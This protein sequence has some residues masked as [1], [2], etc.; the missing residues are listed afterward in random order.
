VSPDNIRADTG[1]SSSDIEA[2]LQFDFERMFGSR[3][4]SDAAVQEQLK[5]TA[6][7]LARIFAETLDPESSPPLTSAE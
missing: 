6:A 1:A 2:R 3:R 5:V 4:L 7:G